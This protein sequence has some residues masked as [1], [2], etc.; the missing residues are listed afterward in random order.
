MSTAIAARMHNGG[1]RAR[2]RFPGR[3]RWRRHTQQCTNSGHPVTEDLTMKDVRLGIAAKTFTTKRAQGKC[4]AETG[5]GAPCVAQATGACTKDVDRRLKAGV[6]EV[7]T[8]ERFRN[9]RIPESCAAAKGQEVQRREEQLEVL[10]TPGEL[11]A[12][13]CAGAMA[14]R[15]RDVGKLTE[16]CECKCCSGAMAR[17]TRRGSSPQGRR[18]PTQG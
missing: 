5:C 12:G 9:I 18:L 15:R 8:D 2:Q 11:L 10:A 13:G 14:T 16:W 3:R 1:G 7:S 4:I 17:R 6:L